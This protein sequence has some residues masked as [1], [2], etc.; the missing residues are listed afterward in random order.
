MCSIMGYF[1]KTVNKEAFMEGFNR[2]K[3]RGPDDTRVIDVP[4]GVLGFHRLAIMGTLTK[5]G[6]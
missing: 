2:T 5:F 1:R 6:Y 4:G 3:S